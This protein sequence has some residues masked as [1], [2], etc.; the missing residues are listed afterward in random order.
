MML[1]EL[2]SP[3]GDWDC[4]KAAV[5]EGADA[6]YFGVGGFNARRRAA[7][8]KF[9]E[10][11]RVVSHCHDAGVRCYLA[12][13]T[14]VKNAELKGFARLLESAYSAGVDAVILQELSFLK[15]LKDAFPDMGVHVSTQA[16]VFNSH[17]APLLAGADRVI[18]PRELTLNQIGQFRRDTGLE[19]EVFVQGALCF[20]VSG[21][22]LMSSIIG[23]RSGNRGLCAQPCRRTY[24]GAYLLSTRDLC[25][26]RALP[27]VVGAGVGSLKIEGRL[28]SREYVAAATAVYRRALDSVGAGAFTVD[29]DAMLD[30]ELAFSREYTEGGM[31]RDYRVVTPKECGKRGVYIGRLG[32]D[33]VLKLGVS[34][35]V[36]DGVGIVTGK[37]EHGDIVRAIESGG[38]AVKQ[39]LRGQTVRLSVNAHEGDEL[40][41]TSGVQRRR[42]ARLH[43]RRRILLARQ[44]RPLVF[45]E[46]L[47]G[48]FGTP[49][50]LAKVYSVSDARAAVSAGAWKAYYD[51]YAKDYPAG[52][53]SVCP[54]VARSLPEW[55]A[56][57]ALRMIEAL[58]PESV[59]S[60]DLG[61]ASDVKGAKV[62]LDVSCNA[63][64]DVDVGFYNA[65]G[66]VPV[67]SPELN[68]DELEAFRDMR[69]AV[70]AHGRLPLMTTKYALDGSSLVDEAGYGF[71]VR[72]EKSQRQIL[73]S[74]ETGFYNEVGRLMA[75]G[76]MEYLLD[77]QAGAAETVSA[78]RRI[79]AGETVAAP[80]GFTTCH[81]RRGVE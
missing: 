41:L 23:G 15:P 70:Y 26:V 5:S 6:V 3:A 40:F 45:Q 47:E 51:V 73:N 74:V 9:E 28:R 38:R 66:L 43:G 19:V 21:Q 8:F 42:P 59:L 67:I 49:R 44:R 65:R 32:R 78:Y 11:P 71:P 29:E 46:P 10:L 33:G 27:K 57:E 4:L 16:G 53:N 34:V 60:G 80:P 2:L 37:G 39:A 64:N 69:F 75:A 7:N 77:I 81:L 76:V 54:Y 68:F 52:D 25:L 55:E 56:D 14:L 62:Y 18:M 72:Q 1:P 50:I 36:G 48:G 30:L 58:G 61:V 12:A 13:N 20:S 63:F 24:N 79:I 22:C 35:M 31:F 17:Y